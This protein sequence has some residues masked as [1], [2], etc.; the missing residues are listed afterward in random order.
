[1]MARDSLPSKRLRGVRRHSSVSLCITTIYHLLNDVICIYLYVFH[2]SNA[3]KLMF[4][5]V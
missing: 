4:V 3:V 2:F 1:M 5:R